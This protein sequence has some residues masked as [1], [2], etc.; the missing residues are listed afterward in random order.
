MASEATPKARKL[1]EKLGVGQA[2]GVETVGRIKFQFYHLGRTH[3][4]FRRLPGGLHYAFSI[5]QENLG[6]AAH[7]R[8]GNC[9][10]SL[11][12]ISDVSYDTY[13]R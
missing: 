13:S 3:R 10:K 11:A 1:V 4:V 6:S 12:T 2:V 5:V 7:A 8:P 9:C